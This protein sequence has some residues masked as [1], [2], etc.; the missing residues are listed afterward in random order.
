VPK[1]EY[2]PFYEKAIPIALVFIAILV[3][4]IMVFILFIL[5]N[6]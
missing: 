6:T 3:I 1:K 5:I 4:V 2:P